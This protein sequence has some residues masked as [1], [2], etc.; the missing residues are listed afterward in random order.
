M[1]KNNKS[2]QLG[3]LEVPE[4]YFKLSKDCKQSVCMM[5]MNDILT[6]IDKQIPQHINRI[7]F[8][9]KVLDSSIETNLEH[10]EYLI[11]Q[12]LSD[13]KQLLND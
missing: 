5:V 1:K 12:V 3:N 2:I 9:D 6:I 11:V 7:E 10:E 4:D 13:V 8:L